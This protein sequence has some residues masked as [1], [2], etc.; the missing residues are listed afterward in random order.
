M[1]GRLA[2][3]LLQSKVKYFIL[4]HEGMQRERLSK[5]KG[6]KATSVT[7]TM[8]TLPYWNHRTVGHRM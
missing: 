8:G 2:M 6:A 4:F 5:F 3:A 1:I 7:L